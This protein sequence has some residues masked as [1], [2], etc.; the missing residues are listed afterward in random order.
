MQINNFFTSG[1]KTAAGDDLYQEGVHYKLY[2]DGAGNETRIANL[3]NP[4]LCSRTG[5]IILT[6]MRS[7]DRHRTKMFF[8]IVIDRK[9]GV[10][11]G[12]PIGID[13]ET[14]KIKFQ[15]II[16]DENEVFDLADAD[17]ARKWA[18]IKNSLFVEGSPN[19]RGKPLYKVKDE[20]REAQVFLSGRVQ[21]RKAIDIAEALFGEALHDMARNLGI[22]PEANSDVTLQAEVIKRA[23]ND[24][25][26]FMAIYD[27]PT[28]KELTIFKRGVAAGVIAMDVV[29]GWNYNGQPLGANEVMA[30]DYL[31][32][33]PQVCQTI[34]LLTKKVDADTDK[35]MTRT[36][37]KH[38]AFVGDDKDARIA[39]LEAELMAK[40][41]ALKKAAAV[42]IVEDAEERLIWVTEGKR[43]NIKGIH[44]IKDLERLKEKVREVN[45]E[46]EG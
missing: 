43:L 9:M 11:W 18:V 20:E 21:K 17:Q 13:P 28:R 41:E 1:N 30:V 45:P 36:P 10:V 3:D 7:G 42:N 15:K 33:Y 25:K 6:P 39:R 26:A 37:V 19:L 44:M 27:S 14:K 5:K 46:F 22:P 24:S 32:E 34:D 31:K 4:D 2:K 16:L 38:T 35:S 12:I 29:N 8:E 40:E 23:E